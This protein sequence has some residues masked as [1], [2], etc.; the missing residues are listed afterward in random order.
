MAYYGPPSYDIS[1]KAQYN[2]RVLAQAAVGGP[3]AL[4]SSDWYH[5]GRTYLRHNKIIEREL[6]SIANRGL[7]TLKRVVPLGSAKDGHMRNELR[8]VY[9]RRAGFR[10]DRTGFAVQYR[11]EKP[12][13]WSA[14]NRRSQF[15]SAADFR[16]A[17]RGIPGPLPSWVE[18]AARRIDR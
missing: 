4:Y 10:K 17:T 13:A 2:A 9:L 5:F 14:A 6:R 7:F 3:A 16:N 18:R 15:A 1:R 8:V 11:G 12:N